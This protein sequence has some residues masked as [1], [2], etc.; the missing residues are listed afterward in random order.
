MAC[1]TTVLALGGSTGPEAQP[2][3]LDLGS[4]VLKEREA[5]LGHGARG[6]GVSQRGGTAPGT[7][8]P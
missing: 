7:A 2:Q 4:T 6:P 3:V 8:F 1:L 5:S